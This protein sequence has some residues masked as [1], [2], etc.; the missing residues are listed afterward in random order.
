MKMKMK[1]SLVFLL[2]LLVGFAGNA[3]STPL[4]VSGLKHLWTGNGNAD[5]S[6]GGAHGTLGTTTSFDTGIN[7]Q[8]F[9]LDGRQSSVVLAPVDIGHNNLPQMT[10]GMLINVDSI[11]NNRDWIMGHDNGGYDRALIINDNRFGFGLAAGVGHTYASSLPQFRNNLNT[12]FGIAVS[13]DQATALATIYINDLLGNSSIQTVSTTLGTGNP[14][15]TLG[16][17]ELFGSHT[18]DALVD[19]V[20]IYDR[21]LSQQELDQVF[22]PV[23]E[24]ATMMLLGIGL[25]GLAGVSRRKK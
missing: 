1:L 24:P 8:A 4:D 10:M 6:V 14:N 25:L 12:W 3:F 5:D 20:F 16:G 19:D 18:V 15:F 7:G 11:Q 2:V 13:Y 22:A 23:P 9:S 21:S 17:L